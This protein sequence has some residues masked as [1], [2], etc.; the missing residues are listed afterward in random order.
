MLLPI[1]QDYLKKAQ[2]K[3]VSIKSGNK[4]LNELKNQDNSKINNHLDLQVNL[5]NLFF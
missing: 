2:E 1:M 4:M 3:E 5:F